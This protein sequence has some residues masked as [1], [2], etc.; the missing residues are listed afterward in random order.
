MA[1]LSVP[2]RPKAKPIGKT[3]TGKP[4]LMPGSKDK[5]DVAAE[6]SFPASDPPAAAAH[7]PAT[8]PNQD[9][10]PARFLKPGELAS[11]KPK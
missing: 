4:T 10:S 9:I 2:H 3:A 8:T 7:P 6:G 5:V 1:R 11:R